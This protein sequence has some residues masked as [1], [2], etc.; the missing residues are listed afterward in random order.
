MRGKLILLATIFLLSGAAQAAPLERKDVPQPLKPWVDWALRGHERELC[1]FLQGNAGDRPCAWP[2]ELTLSLGAKTGRFTQRWRVYGDDP[3]VAL[4]GDD[5]LFPQSV[6][7]DGVPAAV[8]LRGGAPQ[9]RLTRGAHSVSGA[10]AWEELPQLLQIPRETGLLSLSVDGKPVSFPVRDS[11]GRLWVRK[12]Q[13]QSEGKS[14]MRIIVHRKIVDEIP[15]EL[16]TR[17]QLQVSGKTREELLGKALPA[18]FVP[19]SIDGSLPARVE[20]DG[21]LRVQVRP[22]NW[23]ITLRARHEGPVKAVTLGA[24]DGPWDEE[25]AW[26]FESRNHLRLVDVKGAASIDPQ[27]TMLPGEWR[28]FPAYAMRPQTTLSFDERRRGDADPQPDRLSLARVFWLDYD[29]GGLTV[30]DT[31]S[32]ELHRGWRLEMNPRTRLGRA[33]IDGR[34]Q[35]ITALVKDGPSGIEI[36]QGQVNLVADSRV[37]GLG[38]LPAVGWNHDFEQVEASLRLPPGWS[39]LH[40]F[41]VDDASRTWVKRWSLLDIFLVLVIAFAV[42]KLWGNRWGWTALAA[43]ALCWHEPNALKWCWL[44]PLVFEAIHRNIPDGRFRSS[45]TVFRAL[46]WAAL[47]LFAISFMSTDIRGGLYPQLDRMYGQSVGFAGGQG[48]ALQMLELSSMNAAAPAAAPPIPEYEGKNRRRQRAM[49]GVRG[50]ARTGSESD[51]EMAPME[52]ASFRKLFQ[53]E[54]QEPR[55]MTEYDPKAA[56]NTGPGLPNWDWEQ[57]AL[58]WRGPVKKDQTLRLLLLSPCANGILAFV[59][60]GL[61]VCLA[62]LLFGLPVADWLRQLKSGDGFGKFRRWLFPALLLLAVP[63]LNA[64]SSGDFEPSD[65]ILNELR[66]RILE[67]PDCAPHC[68][69]IARMKITATPREAALRLE[70]HADAETAIQLPGGLGQWTPTRVVLD[71]V[72]ASGLRRGPDGTL[73]LRLERGTHQILLE[74]PLPDLES[75]QI[76]LPLIPRRVDASVSGWL[77]DGVSADGRADANLQLSR[78]LKAEDKKDAFET[79]KLPPFVRVERT[80]RLG[81]SWTVHTRVVRMTPLDSSIVLEIPLLPGESVNSEAVRVEN[82]KALLSLGPKAQEGSWTSTLK[83]APSLKFEASDSTPWVEEWTLFVE[84]LWHAEVEG[85]PTVHPESAS[86]MRGRKWR[87]WPGEAVTV[88]VVRPEGVEGQTLTIDSSH[89]ELSPG[90]RATDATLTLSMRSSRGGQHAISLPEG[91]DLQSVKIDGALQPIRQENGKVVLP[92]RPGAHSAELVWRE[93][94]GIGFSFKT[95]AVDLGQPSVNPSIRVQMPKDRWTLM[96]CG[97]RLGPAVLFWPLLL[98]FLLVS[99]GLGRISL[100]PLSWKQWFILSLGLTQVSLLTGGIIALWL[101]WLG[102]R[103]QHPPEDPR[104]FDLQQVF[105]AGL[106]LAALACLFHAITHGLLGVPDMQIA[107]NGSYR[108]SLAWYRDRADAVLPRAWILSVPLWVYRAA[109]LAWALWLASSLIAWLK[110][111]W[112]RWSQGGLWKDLPRMT[113]NALGVGP[114]ASPTPPPPP[115]KKE[116]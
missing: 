44:F 17:V 18:G 53:E 3:W 46:S 16:E 45:V 19:M 61:V 89:L 75:V 36:R 25:E 66:G 24:P 4:P 96:L 10:F 27:Q 81:L 23:T 35:F 100:T 98:V 103:G 51:V 102:W 31:L 48:G 72:P 41:G 106:T 8:I 33:A 80:V 65:K 91:A 11:Q 82:G 68:A 92:V 52:Q 88:S 78:K 2:A 86:Q 26:V 15:L 60:S 107:G 30:Q 64:Q 93:P 115:P 63:N 71:G 40:A 39:L 83:E 108:E 113:K 104:S 9:L 22:G 1:P 94:K 29:G 38:A 76:P 50:A 85:I 12:R 95:S 97:P 57:I 114:K 20:K 14:A 109:M 7:V 49:K 56:V 90:L 6:M 69:E 5:K 79:G 55:Q 116:E 58:S 99:V 62:L 74:G 21:R 43:T 34:D 47:G 111:G 77:L 37:E 13:T 87:P 84:P 105:L 42:G 110:W 73:W 28:G 112:G 101:V 54:R 59:R 67:H 70:A 32:G